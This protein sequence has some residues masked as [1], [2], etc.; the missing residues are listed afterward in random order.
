[1][2]R[3]IFLLFNFLVCSTPCWAQHRYWRVYID[4]IP[5]NYAI[6]TE[7]EMHTA[8]AGSNV[9][10]G[11]T[12]SASSE[13]GGHP[14]SLAFDGNLGTYWM[15]DGSAMPQW[16][17]YDFG[18]SSSPAVIEIKW[19]SLSGYPVRAPETFDVQWSDN[20]ASWT[21]SWSVYGYNWSDAQNQVFTKP[22]NAGSH[23]YW[24]VYVSYTS[25]GGAAACAE[26]EFHSTPGGGNIITGGTPIASTVND[27]Y[28]VANCFDGNPSTFWNSSGQ[29]PQW[30]GYD[31]GSGNSVSVEEIKWTSRADYSLYNPLSFAMQFSDDGTNWSAT[32]SQ[33]G[34]TGWTNGSSQTFTDSTLPPPS[35]AVRH[36][37]QLY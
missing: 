19:G 11:G 20:D 13:Y 12:A 31:F 26:L 30:V 1:M 4:L 9:A 25:S 8:V 34:I 33:T 3:F 15:A 23:R 18:G 5:V 36:R 10:T 37:S 29:P 21:T 2:N 17:E 27:G 24:S 6:A 7:I 32:W 14:A 22:A 16:I 35:T 28:V